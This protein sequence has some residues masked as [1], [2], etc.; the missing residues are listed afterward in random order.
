M[1]YKAYTKVTW[2]KFNREICTE[3]LQ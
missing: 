2:Q 3:Y 1:V